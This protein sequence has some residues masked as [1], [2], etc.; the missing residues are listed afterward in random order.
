MATIMLKF[1]QIRYES[2]QFERGNR[3]TES[4]STRPGKIFQ[5]AYDSVNVFFQLTTSTQESTL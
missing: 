3:T 2:L 5:I 1:W 4:S